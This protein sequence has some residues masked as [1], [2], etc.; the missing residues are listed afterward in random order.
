MHFYIK[1]LSE[2]KTYSLLDFD[3]WEASSCA[4]VSGSGCIKVSGSNKVA[5]EATRLAPPNIKDG[6]H[7]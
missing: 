1:K 6:N 4:T 5:A 3:D 2:Y 7:G